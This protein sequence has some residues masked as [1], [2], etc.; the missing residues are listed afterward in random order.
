[1]VNNIIT[2]YLSNPPKERI[3]ILDIDIPC[4]SNC[5]KNTKFSELLSFDFFKEQIEVVDSLKSLIEDRVDTL[6]RELE[7]RCGEINVLINFPLLA[8]SFFKLVEFGGDY[9]ISIDSLNYEDKVVAKGD[10]SSIMKL[11]KRLEELRKD[12][13]IIGLCNEIK[14]LSESLWVHLDKNIRRALNEIIN[15]S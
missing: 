6:L 5:L 13:N 8:Y 9:V 7:D 1:M 4:S 10:F 2:E 11:Y 14:Y 12:E 15:R 3:K